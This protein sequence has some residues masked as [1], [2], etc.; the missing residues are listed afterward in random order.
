MACLTVLIVH[1]ASTALLPPA[2]CSYSLAYWPTATLRP[3]RLFVALKALLGPFF[4]VHSVCYH[5]HH[6]NETP[7]YLVVVNH[8]R[9]SI[10][11]TDSSPCLFLRALSLVDHSPRSQL[12][13]HPPLA[14]FVRYPLS[15]SPYTQH[16]PS[17]S[18]TLHLQPHSH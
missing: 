15:T 18:P 8:S 1:G 6:R 17:P 7:L 5:S 14:F 16:T 11:G 2:K 3:C 10:K 9:S 12:L 4:T 13:V